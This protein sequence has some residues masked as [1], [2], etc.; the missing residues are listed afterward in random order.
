MK[1]KCKTCPQGSN[2]VYVRVRKNTGLPIITTEQKNIF[3][4]NCCN[5]A[6]CEYIET[7]SLDNTEMI[8]ECCK[9]RLITVDD[10]SILSFDEFEILTEEQA[11]NYIS[12]NIAD[13]ET[14]ED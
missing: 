10:V 14:P 1:G 13:W 12:S 5:N 7:R 3:S 4:N 9:D 11:R 6:Q 2:H 8:I